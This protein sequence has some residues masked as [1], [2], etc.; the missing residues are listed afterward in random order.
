MIT[1]EGK[2]VKTTYI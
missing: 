2:R 1:N